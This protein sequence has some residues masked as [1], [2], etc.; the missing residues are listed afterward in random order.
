MYEAHKRTGAVALKFYSLLKL[1]GKR[2]N[3]YAPASVF[4]GEMEYVQK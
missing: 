4:Y 2:E 3:F 1:C